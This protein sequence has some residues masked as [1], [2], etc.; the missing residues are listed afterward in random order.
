MRTFK[1]LEEF[2]KP[3]KILEKANLANVVLFLSV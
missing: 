2:G 1:N 3:G